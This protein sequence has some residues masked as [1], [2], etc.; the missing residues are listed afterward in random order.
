M[1][2]M[3]IVSIVWPLFLEIPNKQTHSLS[4]AYYKLWRTLRLKGVQC[5]INDI[6]II[7]VTAVVP[8]RLNALSFSAAI[9]QNTHR[10]YKVYSEH[11]YVSYNTSI[12]ALNRE[13]GVGYEKSCLVEHSM[14]MLHELITIKQLHIRQMGAVPILTVNGSKSVPFQT[15]RSPHSGS[16]VALLTSVLSNLSFSLTPSRCRTQ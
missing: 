15:K 3:V 14:E 7:T 2:R 10:I 12:T 4:S 16:R 1:A 11:N 5:T 13:K 9:Y 8:L 6:I